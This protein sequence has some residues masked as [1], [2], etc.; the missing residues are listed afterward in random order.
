MIGREFKIS[1]QRQSDKIVSLQFADNKIVLI[2]EVGNF[3]VAEEFH[4]FFRMSS[5]SYHE[6]YG[7]GI[8][9]GQFLDRP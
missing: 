3:F 5:I 6:F 8:M 1:L 4:R 2:S 9:R 7:C